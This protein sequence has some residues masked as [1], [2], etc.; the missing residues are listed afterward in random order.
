MF[1]GYRL[2]DGSFAVVRKSF[3]M[4]RRGVEGT[5]FQRTTKVSLV[6]WDAIGWL[7]SVNLFL[8]PEL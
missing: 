7:T 5:H 6:G 8:M 3:H 2:V 1:R 4:H